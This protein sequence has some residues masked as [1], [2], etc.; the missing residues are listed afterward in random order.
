MSDHLKD[1]ISNLT[2]PAAPKQESVPSSGGFLQSNKK[3]VQPPKVITPAHE[4][5]AA[6]R[7]PA[8][9]VP[10]IR[11]REVR[12]EKQAARDVDYSAEVKKVL[13]H[14]VDP[15]KY[16]VAPVQ[17][18]VRYYNEDVVDWLGKFSRKNV[19]R[20]GIALTQS[21]VIENIL[22]V[23]IYDLDLQPI[24]FESGEELRQYILQKLK[25]L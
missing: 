6:A 8:P 7:E 19:Q 25:D 22:Q 14:D 3:T 18:N 24:G 15:D 1:L 12:K 16:G 11:E 23:M 13:R 2:G 20:G 5:V 21:S 4:E 9:A 10:V 17:R